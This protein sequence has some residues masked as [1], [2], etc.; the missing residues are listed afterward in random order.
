MISLLLRFGSALSS[1]VLLCWLAPVGVGSGIAVPD[2]TGPSSTRAPASTSYRP[3]DEDFSLTVSPTRLAV[4][5]ADIGG[6]KEILVVNRGRVALAVTVK[7]KNFTSSPDGS[8][9]FQDDAPYA[10][11]D[12]VTV[13]P[14]SFDLAPGATR[15]VTAAISVPA[16]PETGDHQV[17]IV[18]T[19]PSGQTDSNVKINRGIATPIYIT[20]PGPVD[21]SISLG[22]MTAPWFS[23]DGPVAITA[24]VHSTGTVHRD[25]RGKAALAVDA[26]G[27]PA[28]FPDFTVLRG[29]TRDVSTTWE[30][31]LMCVCHPSSSIVRADGSIDTRTVRV[32]VFPFHLLGAL[33]AAALII[34][35]VVRLRKRRFHA[36]V[37]AAARRVTPAAGTD[38]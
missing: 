3:V 34:F 26:A 7:K 11:A 8:L 5:P 19:V 9:V 15:A 16:D 6:T 12:W 2:P 14:T 33:L 18:F 37:L 13:A 28:A 36:A 25:F 20:V 30:P 24:Q 32:I 4:G 10:A 27:S 22:D 23:L 21:D 35:L 1:A 38:A 31:P 17:A 29:A